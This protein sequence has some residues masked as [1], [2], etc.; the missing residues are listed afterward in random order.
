MILSD[1][2][3]NR[4]DIISTLRPNW[5]G[6]DAEPI[7]K[8]VINNV[9]EVIK[10]LTNIL[11]PEMEIFPT[12]A[13]SIQLEWTDDKI[14]THLEFE[15]YATNITIFYEIGKKYEDYTIKLDNYKHMNKL[16]LDLFLNKE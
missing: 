7:P 13:D 10:H 12:A 11:N 8:I 3:K 15:I 14:D 4:L 6:Y 1:K 5:N 9:N 2:N 16:L